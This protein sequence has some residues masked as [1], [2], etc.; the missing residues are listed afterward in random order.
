VEFSTL[1]KLPWY[2]EYH[3][4]KTY[5]SEMQQNISYHKML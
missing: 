2:L 4:L 3:V 1:S 5:F